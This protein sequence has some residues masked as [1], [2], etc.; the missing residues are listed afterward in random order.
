MLAEI[1][2]PPPVTVAQGTSVQVARRTA[3]FIADHLTEPDLSTAVMATALGFNADY[4]GVRFVPPS[5][6][7]LPT[8][9]IAC[10]STGPGCS[11]DQPAG[12]FSG[13]PQTSAS[14]TIDTSAGSSNGPSVSRPDSSS[15]C[16][17]LANLVCRS[18]AILAPKTR[19]A[20][21]GILARLEQNRAERHPHGG[22][23][24]GR[25]SAASPNSCSDSRRTASS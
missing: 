13:W 12:P 9:S 5:T 6:R 20:G 7:R 1:L 3:G 19:N 8:T 25:I 16:D 15:V 18:A 10:E 22:Y 21:Y 2:H 24:P 23:I 14:T 4:L 17:H 11:F